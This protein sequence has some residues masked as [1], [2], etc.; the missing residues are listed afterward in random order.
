M[1]DK[2]DYIKAVV[3]QEV[4]ED[5]EV[6]PRYEEVLKLHH[7]TLVG[8]DRVNEAKYSPDV[9]PSKA[10]KPLLK[11]FDQPKTSLIPEGYL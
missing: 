1:N 2:S 4:I 7:G 8:F 9:R 11:R 3:K 6:H 10:R 5:Q